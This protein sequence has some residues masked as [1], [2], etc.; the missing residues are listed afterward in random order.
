MNRE[1]K[2]K[3]L[4]IRITEAQLESLKQQIKSNPKQENLSAMMREIIHNY[5]INRPR[6]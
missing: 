3:S 4:T 5:S 6:A 1:R 2:S